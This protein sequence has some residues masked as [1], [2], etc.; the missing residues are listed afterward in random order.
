MGEFLQLMGKV[1]IENVTFGPRP[2]RR[3]GVGHE[4]MW[5]A[6]CLAGGGKAVVPSVNLRQTSMSRGQARKASWAM[7][8]P[9]NRAFGWMV[10]KRART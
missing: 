4:E 9:W 10:L 5:G 1:F 3:K 6:V 8:S 7:A 2:E